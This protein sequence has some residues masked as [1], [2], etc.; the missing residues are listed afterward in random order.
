MKVTSDSAKRSP[1]AF[2]FGV[3]CY[4]PVMRQWE[5]QSVRHLLDAGLA[6]P[7]LV[8]IDASQEGKR[9]GERLLNHGRPYRPPHGLG[10]FLNR[11]RALAPWS[12]EQLLPGI[13]RIRCAPI[14][15][16]PETGQF[17]QRDIEEIAAH[18]LD[19]ILRFAF[20]TIRGDVL[21]IPRY[22]IWSFLHGRHD[23]HLARAPLFREMYGG[24]S[25]VR[26]LLERLTDERESTAV[27]REGY[28]NTIKHSYGQSIDNVYFEA[29]RWPAR[30]CRG[31][32]RHLLHL[33]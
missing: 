4:G 17:S 18:R 13:P 25:V 11:S 1:V 5:V 21:N 33:I 22:G 12:L 15:S 20:R 26:V 14:E 29:A 3:M 27:L 28:V 23:D 2:R 6:K 30:Q 19:F 31:S 9:I 24:E 8:I 10:L 16:G 32:G 7:V